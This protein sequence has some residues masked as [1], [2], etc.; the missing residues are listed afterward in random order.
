MSDEPDLYA[1]LATIAAAARAAYADG[2]NLRVRSSG[3]VHEVAMT[4]W[5]A[6]ERMPGPA[7]MVGVSGWDPGAAHPDRGP[8]TCRRC[9][10][11]TSAEPGSEQLTLFGTDEQDASA[12]GGGGAA[13]ATA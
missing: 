6:D 2:S 11:L 13:E 3:I 9:L 8:V 10:K 4:K 7:C 12:D 1:A 5:F